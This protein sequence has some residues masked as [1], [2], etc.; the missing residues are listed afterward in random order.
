MELPIYGR[1]LN[2]DFIAE[3]ERLAASEI[4]RQFSQDLNRSMLEVVIL[5]VRNGEIIPVITTAVSR[6]QWLENP[7]IAVWTRYNSLS[8]TLLHRNDEDNGMI[9]TSPGSVAPSFSPS[10]VFNDPVIQVEQAFQEGRLSR[11]EFE[12]LVD[13]LD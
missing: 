3:A 10:T 12:E 6:S 8:Y 9:P 11:D 13:E 1:V 4:E 2:R 7:Q 5:G